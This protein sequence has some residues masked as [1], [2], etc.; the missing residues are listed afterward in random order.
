MKGLVGLQAS[1]GIGFQVEAL[2]L[3]VYGE[4]LEYHETSDKS[5]HG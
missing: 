1:S 4:D 2:K 3:A 5:V